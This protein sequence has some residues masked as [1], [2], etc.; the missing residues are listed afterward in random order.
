MDSVNLDLEVL[1]Q[2]D[3]SALGTPNLDR[4]EA[5]YDLVVDPSCQYRLSVSFKKPADERPGDAAPEFQGVCEQSE[6]TGN[7]PDGKPWHAPRRHWMQL[8]PYVFDTTGF[9]H[10][11]IYWRPCGLP[12]KGLRAPRFDLTFY[13]V[14]P[15]YRA[16]WTC[17]EVRTPRI[18]SANQTSTFGRG[19]FVV[20]RMERDPMFLANLP[21]G[22]NP[23]PLEPEA[24]QYEGMFSWNDEQIPQTAA[25]FKLPQFDLSTYDGDVVAFRTMLPYSRFSGGNS[26]T[27]SENQFF[28]YQTM[29]QLPAAWNTTYDAGTGLITVILGGTAGICGE[30]FDAAKDEQEEPVATRT[31]RG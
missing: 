10:M 6:N 1:S 27:S 3:L 28:L 11:S 2:I 19:H 5:T 4:Y 13:T 16:F 18:C 29:P 24:Y 25:D 31:L 17:A 9:D 26:T 7:A 12:P 22:F 21:L 30:T 8:P 23:D 14:L 20:G 15:Q